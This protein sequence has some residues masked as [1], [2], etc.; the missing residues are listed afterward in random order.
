MQPVPKVAS[1]RVVYIYNSY[2]DVFSTLEGQGFV[3]DS[4]KASSNALQHG[5]RFALPERPFLIL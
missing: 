4:N 1:P 2:M 5:V 3:W